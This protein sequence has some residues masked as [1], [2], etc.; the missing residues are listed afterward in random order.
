MASRQGFEPRL[1]V[2]ETDVLPLNTSEILVPPGGNDPPTDA[3][4]ASVIPFN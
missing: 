3:Y 1:A 4:Q 2:L